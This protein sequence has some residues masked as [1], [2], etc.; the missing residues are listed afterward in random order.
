MTRISRR[1]NLADD[2]QHRRQANQE[3]HASANKNSGGGT[4]RRPGEYSF[5]FDATDTNT[6][7]EV[8]VSIIVAG[9][10]RCHQVLGSGRGDL[11]CGSS[12]PAR[13]LRFKSAQVNVGTW[14]GAAVDADL[15]PATYQQTRSRSPAPRGGVN[16]NAAQ[17][18]VNVVNF[19]GAAGTFASGRPEITVAAGGIAS[20]SFAAGA[21]NS[22][23]AQIFDVAVS[24]RL[25]S[26]SYTA[27]D[28]STISTINGKLPADTTSKLANLD[29]TISSR[30]DRHRNDPY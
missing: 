23:V 5:T 11:R 3:R 12:V 26:G 24:S 15:C 1:P 10:G 4:H 8:K 13:R 29:A 18:G 25:A 16:A 27:P 20:S 28:N 9:T 19:G 14:L 6:V 22:T 17:I 7:G 21:I 2:R 30:R